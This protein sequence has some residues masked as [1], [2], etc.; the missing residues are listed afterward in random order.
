MHGGRYCNLLLNGSDAEARKEYGT[1]ITTDSAFLDN[2]LD[3]AENTPDDEYK[4]KLEVQSGFIVKLDGIFDEVRIAYSGLKA[5]LEAQSGDKSNDKEAEVES[6]P[7]GIN[8]QAIHR[9]LEINSRAIDDSQF[10]G[11]A[12][13][14]LPNNSS[15]G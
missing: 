7:R 3:R 15:N 5:V 13:I 4:R 6:S 14:T 1:M 8:S 9:M 11:E 10:T 12:D 2:I